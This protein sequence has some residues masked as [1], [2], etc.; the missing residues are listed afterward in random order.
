M[1]FTPSICLCKSLHLALQWGFEIFK[2]YFIN[3]EGSALEPLCCSG[4]EQIILMLRHSLSPSTLLKKKKKRL[5]NLERITAATS[6]DD[7]AN[8]GEMNI[9]QSTLDKPS[10]WIG[11]HGK[12]TWLNIVAYFEQ[13]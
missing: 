4:S 9:L 2:K 7:L 1:Y 5:T 11:Y 8:V 3:T 10:Q 12:G 6:L 13:L